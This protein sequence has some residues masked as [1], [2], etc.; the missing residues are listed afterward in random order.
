MELET[1]EHVLTIHV[2]TAHGRLDAFSVPELR[3][4]LLALSTQGGRHFVV[5]LSGVDFLDSA[6]MAALVSL[7]KHA[8]Q[9]GGDVHLVWPAS[10][11]AR[12]ILHLT[13]FDRVFKMHDNVDE[14]LDLF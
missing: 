1:R 8:R 4:R 9:V 3:E 6:G 2:V 12:R 11:A 5:D 14:A 10:D 7:L 13:R